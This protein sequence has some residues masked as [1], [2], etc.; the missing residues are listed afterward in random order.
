M[1]QPLLSVITVTKDDRAGFAATRR[2]LAG[3]RWTGFQW[4]VAD[5]G[6][7]D[8]TLE[9][10]PGPGPV[11]DWWDSR[12]DGGPFVGM[13][14]AMAQ[15]R[16]RYL[17]FLNGGDRLADPDSL[18]AVAALLEAESPDLLYGHALEDP[19]TGRMALK[20]CRHWRWAWY[21]MPA[22]H[23]AMVYGRSATAGLRFDEGLRVAADYAFTLQAIRRSRHI[24][25][26]PEPLAVFAPGGLSRRLPA[27]GRR[28]QDRVRA[29]V[30]RL[31]SVARHAITVA[32]L[33]MAGIRQAHP[34]TY[35]YLRFRR[36][37]Y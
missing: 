11:P 13:N 2:S 7:Q 34:A 27:L 29:E 36:T 5:G 19:G 33:C 4:L 17:L 24:R 22:H 6:S 18:G 3:Q 12:A 15:A 20:P 9:D 35:A 21:G 23:C 16:G 14:R 26:W 30:L 28:E 8:G 32:Q 10:L 1:G 31:P 25:I 37:E